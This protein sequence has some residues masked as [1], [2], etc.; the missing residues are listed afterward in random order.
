MQDN[1]ISI[2]IGWLAAHLV[3]FTLLAFLLVGLKVFGVF[4]STPGVKPPW[5]SEATA[6]VLPKARQWPASSAESPAQPS[7][8]PATST[9]PG[10]S[11]QASWRPPPRMSDG[12]RPVDRS[13][14]GMIPPVHDRFRPESMPDQM[15]PGPHSTGEAMLQQARK[16][17][18]NGNF[19]GAEEAYITLITQYPDDPDTYGELGN[20]YQA[21]GRGDAALD[22]YFEA[23]VR[24]KR[25]GNHEKFN[26]II[27]L[28]SKQGDPRAGQLSR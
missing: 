7:G 13:A 5:A 16:A 18:W 12:D 28:L 21:M 15:P 20:L 22:A 25:R 10:E 11:E 4:E 8:H 6:D 1:L 27:E 23:A 9:G 24:L 2:V 14:V 19:E 26:Y 17:F 3:F